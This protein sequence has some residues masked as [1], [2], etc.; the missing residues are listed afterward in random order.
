MG[1]Y[2]LYDF[3]KDEMIKIY[4]KEI[5]NGKTFFGIC[6]QLG[7]NTQTLQEI[8]RSAN[9]TYSMKHKRYIKDT[10]SKRKREIIP[11]NNPDQMYDSMKNN[12][13]EVTNKDLLKCMR[14]I[15]DE[16]K[17]INS[18]IDKGI[19][20]ENLNKTI[21]TGAEIEV[22]SIKQ[23]SIKVDEDTINRFNELCKEYEH[24]NK[25]YM[26]SLAIKE[27]CDKYEK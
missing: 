2:R 27:F 17:N 1:R 12:L 11:G 7:V 8:L 24:I 21:V 16:I 14:S 3:T 9:Y 15:Q 13:G 6:K 10:S 4:E 18:R 26:L 20:R 5:K 22:K 19:V 25:S 23:T